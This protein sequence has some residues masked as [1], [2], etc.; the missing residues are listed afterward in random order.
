MTFEVFY[1]GRHAK[2]P[3]KRSHRRYTAEGCRFVG[4]TRRPRD[5]WPESSVLSS[6]P[7]ILQR[8]AGATA[9]RT[10][11]W[12]VSMTT[13][14]PKERLFGGRGGLNATTI[15]NETLKKRRVTLWHNRV[16]FLV[17]R[18]LERWFQPLFVSVWHHFIPECA[19]SYVGHTWLTHVLTHAGTQ[20]GVSPGPPASLAPQ[21]TSS[22]AVTD[23]PSSASLLPC[24]AFRSD[25][26]RP[27]RVEHHGRSNVSVV[28][29]GD[30]GGSK[31][32]SSTVS[33]RVC[34]EKSESSM[35]K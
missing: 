31:L 2:V 9:G 11:T 16:L 21:V 15:E 35:V 5:V 19:F 34:G 3:S 24:S 32:G 8:T 14:S 28:V 25:S 26:N 27:I 17:P 6:E 33:E 7:Q 30:P 22:S 23:W 18:S 10:L 12:E 20:Q 13:D 29:R 1:A 4:F